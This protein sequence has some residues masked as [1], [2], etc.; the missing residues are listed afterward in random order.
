MTFY[1]QAFGRNLGIIRE[2]EQEKLRNSCVAIAG[3]GGVG[4]I[5]L[6]TLAR[7]GIGKFHIADSDVFETANLNRQYGAT[8]GTFG[9]KKVDVMKEI[10]KAINPEAEIKTFPEG[11]EKNNIDEFLT[12]VDVAIDGI[13]AFEINARRL[14]FNQARD[15]GIYTVTS[16]PMGF[17]SILL[18]FDPRGMSFDDYFGISDKSSDQENTAAFLVGIAPKLLHL[19]YLDVSKANFKSRTGPSIASACAL[20][21]SLAATETAKILLKRGAVKPAPHYFQ[22]DPYLQIYEK[23]RLFWGG[24]NPIHQLKKMY[25]LRKLTRNNA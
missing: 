20:C 9:R 11:I 14:L 1:D 16:G 10:V 21:A 4:G 15:K 12:G 7:M 24:R 23:G 6:V 22:F 3:M 5:H 19:K 8:A 18:T 17:S 2:G 13:D 25:V